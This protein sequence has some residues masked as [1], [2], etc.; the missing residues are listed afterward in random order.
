VVAAVSEPANALLLTTSPHASHPL[1][2]Q[3]EASTLSSKGLADLEREKDRARSALKD[4]AG[5]KQ[6]EFEAIRLA[7]ESE[8]TNQHDRVREY[9]GNPH[10]QT[11]NDHRTTANE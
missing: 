9:H 1:S 11:T 2:L 10:H 7:R 6:L 8:K 5:D 4:K 3:R